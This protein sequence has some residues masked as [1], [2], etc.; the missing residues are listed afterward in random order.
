MKDIENLEELRDYLND[1]HTLHDVEYKVGI[2]NLPTFGELGDYELVNNL[3]WCLVRKF[4]TN[5][6]LCEIYSYDDEN[7]MLYNQY[8]YNFYVMSNVCFDK[9]LFDNIEYE[10]K[11]S[12]YDMKI[13]GEHCLGIRWKNIE[14]VS[15]LDDYII[16][17]D[18]NLCG[19]LNTKRVKLARKR[20]HETNSEYAKS[21]LRELHNITNIMGGLPSDGGNVLW[22]KVE[23]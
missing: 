18:Y 8:Y 16:K 15:L 13:T 23:D 17:I 11:L 3:D 6:V 14:Q 10:A 2:A 7:V 9:V 21:T 20:E 19:A 12:G 5:S 22:L 4:K 1:N